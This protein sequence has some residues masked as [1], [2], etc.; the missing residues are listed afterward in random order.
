MCA[1]DSRVSSTGRPSRA[2][3]ST[4]SALTIDVR[5]RGMSPNQTVLQWDSVPER[6]GRR[7]PGLSVAADSVH[8]MEGESMQLDLA[9]VRQALEHAREALAGL[10]AVM[11]Q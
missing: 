9:G 2:L 8:L 11:Y 7:R 5:G 3:S 6:P 1:R 10:D 4:G